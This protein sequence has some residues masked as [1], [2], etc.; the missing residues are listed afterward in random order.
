MP[1]LAC[2]AS[3]SSELRYLFFMPGLD[4][5]YTPSQGGG[6]GGSGGNFDQKKGGGGGAHP[7][8]QPCMPCSLDSTCTV[9]LCVNLEICCGG[10]LTH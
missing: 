5:S 8:H 6:G 10:I 7:L 1:G 3:Q 2:M 9:T 4:P